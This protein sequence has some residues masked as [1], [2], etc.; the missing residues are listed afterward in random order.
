MWYAER[1]WSRITEPTLERV[2]LLRCQLIHGAAT[3]GSTLNRG[4]LTRVNGFLAEFLPVALTVWIEH[5]AD[6]DWGPMCYP[7][8]G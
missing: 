7:P 1:Q 2:Y 6:H 8:Q 4:S 3:C 5:G